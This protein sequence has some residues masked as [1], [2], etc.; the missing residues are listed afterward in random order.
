MAHFQWILLVLAM[1]LWHGRSEAWSNEDTSSHVPQERELETRIVYYKWQSH[2]FWSMMVPSRSKTVV[3]KTTRIKP[4]NI[5]RPKRKDIFSRGGGGNRSKMSRT[6]MSTTKSKNKSSMM[7]KKQSKRMNKK[8]NHSS[9]KGV[10][11]KRNYRRRPSKGNGIGKGKGR[12]PS[13]PTSRRPT[14][15][16]RRPPYRK[17][18]MSPVPRPTPDSDPDISTDFSSATAETPLLLFALAK[19]GTEVVVDLSLPNNNQV[20]E[21]YIVRGENV[22]PG[23]SC[24]PA[25]GSLVS[26]INRQRRTASVPLDGM[27]SIVALCVDDAV[28]AQSYYVFESPDDV[29]GDGVVSMHILQGTNFFVRP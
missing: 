5:G 17:P 9:R 11:P 12:S 14:R 21:L 25:G 15:P 28:V 27:S 13:K 29:G 2:P 18:T 7:S 1:V 22:V 10:P 4:Y 24:P 20:D 23:S 16:T 6:A 8:R 19:E 3:T 26:T